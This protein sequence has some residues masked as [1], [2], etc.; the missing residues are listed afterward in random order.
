[1]A[2]APDS[3]VVAFPFLSEDPAFLS[4]VEVGAVFV[5]MNQRAP[6]IFGAYHVASQE[7]LFLLAHKFGYAFEWQEDHGLLVVSFKLNEPDHE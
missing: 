4:G 1:M 7:Q 2:E 3:P 5:L 6:V